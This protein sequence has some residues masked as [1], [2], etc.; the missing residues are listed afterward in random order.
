MSP[1]LGK[2]NLSSR[3]FMGC[4]VAF[5]TAVGENVLNGNTWAVRT[6]AISSVR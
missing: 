2:L 1:S 3:R 5:Q 4:G 6:R